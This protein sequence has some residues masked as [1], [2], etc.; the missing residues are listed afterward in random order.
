MFTGSGSSVYAGECVAVGLQERLAIPVAAVAAGQLLTHPG[1]SVPP[2]GPFGLVSFGRSG[3]SPESRAVVDA[4]LASEPRA[5][6]LVVTC[7]GNGALAT[8]YRAAARV[9]RYSTP[10]EG[11]VPR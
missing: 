7:N 6:H 4:L 2:S 10:W 9:R 3:N 8:E 1:G 5:S 11:G